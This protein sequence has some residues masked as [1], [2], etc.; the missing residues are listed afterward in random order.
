VYILVQKAVDRRKFGADDRMW[1]IFG[2]AYKYRGVRSFDISSELK[3]L[4]YTAL[5]PVLVKTLKGMHIFLV[6]DTYQVFVSF[7]ERKGHDLH[8]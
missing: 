3:N 4:T 5:S 8:G 6:D 7:T 2:K 1:V